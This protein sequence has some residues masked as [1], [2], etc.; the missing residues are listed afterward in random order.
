MIPLSIFRFFFYS[1]IVSWTLFVIFA[2][3][4]FFLRVRNDLPSDSNIYEKELKTRHRALNDNKQ[5]ALDLEKYLK[6]EAKTT[7]YD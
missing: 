1:G 7:Q 3:I 6:G 5:F 4:V 2:V